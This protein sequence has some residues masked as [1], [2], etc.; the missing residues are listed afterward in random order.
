MI[1]KIAHVVR[2]TNQEVDVICFDTWATVSGDEGQISVSFNNEKNNQ[3]LPN[4]ITYR[5]PSHVN[6]WKTEKF[7]QYAFSDKMYGE[8]FDFCELCYPHINTGFN[9]GKILHY[10]VYDKDI[11]QAFEK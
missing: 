4:R 6:A 7:Q 8:D 5:K 10:Y 1:S 11:T 3:F 9:I 2:I